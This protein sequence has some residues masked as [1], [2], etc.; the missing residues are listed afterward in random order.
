MM[1]TVNRVNDF[2]TG[3]CKGKSYSVPYND[4]K[5]ALMKG[6]VDEA[7]KATLMADLLTTISQFE[8]FTKDSYKVTVEH[9]TPYL[10]V[11]VSTGEFFLHKDGELSKHAIPGA[12]VQRIIRAVET[13]N[14]LDPTIKSLVRF[15]RN[16]NYS[17]V[18]C[19]RFANYLNQTHVDA[20]LMQRLIT[21]GVSDAMARER[22]TLFQTSL[23]AEGLLNTYKVSTEITKKYVKD[24]TED[25]AVKHVNKYDFEV[26]EVTGLKTY[27]I[28]EF[29]ED[30]VFQPAIMGTRGDAFYCGEKEG[31]IIKV[32][33]VHWLDNWDKVDCNDG[34]SGQKGL[35]VGNLDYIRNFQNAGTV[36]HNIFIDPMDIG[37]ITDDGSGALRVLRYF[38]HSSFAGI[39]R[40]YYH[41]SRYAAITDAAYAKM[42]EEAIEAANAES[43]KAIDE[44]VGK[45]K[46]INLLQT[47]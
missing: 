44:A 37:A 4:E 6:L 41:S 47:F 35:H 1:I 8:P 7:A 15:M 16:P 5:F 10:H 25:D 18:K 33:E 22:S 29:V 21:D 31:H 14:D 45:V 27:K 32:G 9:K 26:D 39:N 17:A 2:I 3:T 46:Q 11:N 34:Y 28:P 42:V 38:V 13:N 36:T 23:T 24:E 12:F 40:G 20:E 19:I 30:R 43:Q